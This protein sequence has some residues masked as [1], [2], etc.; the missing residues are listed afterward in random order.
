MNGGTDG[1]RFV[2]K[3]YAAIPTGGIGSMSALTDVH[4]FA[5]KI[6]LSKNADFLEKEAKI[7]LQGQWYLDH[8]YQCVRQYRLTATMGKS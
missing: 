2:A 1:Q 6:P 8:F 5:E 7:Q 3:R 4:Q